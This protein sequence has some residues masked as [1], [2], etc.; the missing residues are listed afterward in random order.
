MIKLVCLDMAGTTVSD[1]GVVMAAFD[2]AITSVGLEADALADAREV[3][4]ATMG[5]SKIDVFRSILG[6]SAGRVANRRFEDS[7]LRAVRGGAVKSLP[8]AEEALTWLRSREIK[9]CFVTG[10][11]PV[12]RD[13]IIA[14]LGWESLT[15]LALSPADAGRGRPYP[16]MILTAIIRLGIADVRQV[17]VVG[18]NPDDLVAG[19]RA[20]AAMIIGVLSGSSSRE[21]LADVAPTHI[22]EG[23]GDLIDLQFD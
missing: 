11:S 4:I 17:A 8:G 14:R 1:D 22:V 12:I 13:S 10:F 7:Y 18:D 5:R 3:V 20:G 21:R 2:E 15:D 19:Q 23:V 6:N 16:D 9:T